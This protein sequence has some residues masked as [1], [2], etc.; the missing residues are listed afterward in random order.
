LRRPLRAQIQSAPEAP[1]MK[2]ALSLTLAALVLGHVG[3]ASA[4]EKS[5]VKMP[6]RVTVAGKA[7]VLNGM[8]VREATMFN[9]NVYVAGLYLEK[10]TQNP[11]EVVTSE[12]VKRIDLVFVRDVDR[13]DITDAWNT[14][15]K[16]NGADMTRLKPQITQL[17]G[18]MAEMEEDE[19]LSFTYV[20]TKGLTVVVKGKEKGTIPG[21]D[22][23]HAF[24]AIWFGRSPPNKGLKSGML[25]K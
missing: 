24:F 25:G 22:F 18:W 3:T 2:R 17:N 20:P 21:A 14:Q 1:M 4:G 7:L 23:G 12:Q 11:D 10:K 5:G 15:F 6:D 16:S 19:T 13:E 9:V 8:G